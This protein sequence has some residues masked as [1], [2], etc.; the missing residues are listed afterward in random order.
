MTRRLL[1]GIG[2]TIALLAL[3]GCA[4]FGNV[5]SEE[6]L[7]E[8]ATYDW[9]TDANVTIDLRE[10]TYTAVYDIEDRSS[11]RVYQRTRYGIEDPLAIRS[12][13]FR[14]PNGTV[15][16]ASAFEVSETRSAVHL[17]LPAENGQLAYTAPKRSKQFSTTVFVEGSWEVIVPEGH[18]VDNM[19]LATVRPGGYESRLEEDRVHLTW[20]SVTSRSVR[21]EYYLARDLYL[22]VGLIAL[23]AVA[24][25]AGIGYVYRQIQDLRRERRELG[26]DLEVD[27]DDDRPPPGMR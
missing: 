16:E 25:V 13:Q 11:I 6:G 2:L 14:Y 3:A 12:L 15:V 24:G 23:A 20:D 18:R 21:V 27:E 22:F 17:E 19:V 9:E 1:L 5:T 7:S 26:L 10:D 8:G 4:S